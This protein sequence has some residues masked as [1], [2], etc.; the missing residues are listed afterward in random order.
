MQIQRDLLIFK[1][2]LRSLH[3][4]EEKYHEIRFYLISFEL[5]NIKIQYFVNQPS[6]L[7]KICNAKKSLHCICRYRAINAQSVSKELAV[8]VVPLH[9]MKIVLKC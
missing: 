3:E 9:L 1:D 5:I 2:T 7:F 8:P 6:F 4:N